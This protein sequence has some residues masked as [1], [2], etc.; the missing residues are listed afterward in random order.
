MEMAIDLSLSPGSRSKIR[1]LNYENFRSL[2][3]CGH[4]GMTGIHIFPVSAKKIARSLF[5]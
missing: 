1:M 5:W 4:A 3:P 2:S